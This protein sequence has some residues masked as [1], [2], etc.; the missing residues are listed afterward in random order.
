MMRESWHGSFIILHSVELRCRK[1]NTSGGIFLLSRVGA[2]KK[3]YIWPIS[4]SLIVFCFFHCVRLTK[5]SPLQSMR[6]INVPFVKKN[7]CQKQLSIKNKFLMYN[8]LLLYY[9]YIP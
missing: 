3:I 5:P 2:A 7:S 6:T 8:F 9:L 4:K 1:L